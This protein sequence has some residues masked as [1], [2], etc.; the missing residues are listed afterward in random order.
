MLSLWPHGLEVMEGDS[1]PCREELALVEFIFQPLCFS[2]CPEQLAGSCGITS[3][4]H[5]YCP[6]SKHL[7]PCIPVGSS[8]CPGTLGNKVFLPGDFLDAKNSKNLWN[9]YLILE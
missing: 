5:K 8:L 4:S 7:K 6:H 9:S 3:Q 1:G 2:S